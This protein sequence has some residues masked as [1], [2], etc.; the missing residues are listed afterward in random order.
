MAYGTEVLR[1]K[2]FQSFIDPSCLLSLCFQQL[3]PPKQCQKI[4][5][6]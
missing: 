4:E 5:R 1:I 6:L 2:I 3:L